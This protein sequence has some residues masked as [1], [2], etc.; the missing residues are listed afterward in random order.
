MFIQQ[1]YEEYLV[2]Y[3]PELMLEITDDFNSLGDST[4]AIDRA[5]QESV[6]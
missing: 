4:M 5:Q 3:V 1:Y 6:T 2:G